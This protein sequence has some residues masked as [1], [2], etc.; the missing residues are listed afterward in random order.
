M[1]LII[2]SKRRRRRRRASVAKIALLLAQNN[3]ELPVLRY[4]PTPVKLSLII[5][6]NQLLSHYNFQ[7][8]YFNPAWN[9]SDGRRHLMAVLYFSVQKWLRILLKNSKNQQTPQQR[10]KCFHKWVLT[11]F[12]NALISLRKKVTPPKTEVS[13]SDLRLTFFSF[14]F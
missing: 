14:F 3:S 2:T 13:L 11:W 8:I 7:I 1:Q 9:D 12:A 4:R 6:M 5:F 10:F